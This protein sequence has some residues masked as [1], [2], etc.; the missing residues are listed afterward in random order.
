M[1]VY[2]N[3]LHYNRHSGSTKSFSFHLVGPLLSTHRTTIQN[4]VTE[5]M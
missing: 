2:N 3:L 4:W 1:A 5:L